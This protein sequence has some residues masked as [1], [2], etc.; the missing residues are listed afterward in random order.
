VTEIAEIG[1]LLVD[2]SRK[3]TAK[4]RCMSVFEPDERT[5]EVL[6]R[7][8]HSTTALCVFDMPPDLAEAAVWEIGKMAL[9][10]KPVPLVQQNGY[11]W[12]LREVSRL[13]RTKRGWNLALELE[14]CLVK[15]VRYRLDPELLQMLLCECYEHI[16]GMTAEAIEM[17]GEAHNSE[18]RIP[19][20]ESTRK[21]R[22]PNGLPRRHES[23]EEEPGS[24]TADKRRCTRIEPHERDSGTG[25]L[26]SSN[27]GVLG[28]ANDQRCTSNVATMKGGGDE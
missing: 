26:E 9:E 15:W 1:L 28:S 8:R 19:N 12:Y 13:L 6:D 18:A 16:A 5:R 24:A 10:D 20:D 23:H 25:P 17:R 27:P 4:E 3:S 22:S 7:I 2:G 14:I 11:R 21:A